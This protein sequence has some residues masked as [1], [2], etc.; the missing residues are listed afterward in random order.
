M[1]DAHCSITRPLPYLVSRGQVLDLSRMEAS[2]F[3]V[4]KER[5]S[6]RRLARSAVT[7]MAPFARAN[8]VKLDVSVNADVPPVVLVDPNR[9]SQA[10]TNLLSN[11]SV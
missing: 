6:V 9:L 5:T 1:N 10:L 7:Q 3:S 8:H 4:K 11:V 2:A